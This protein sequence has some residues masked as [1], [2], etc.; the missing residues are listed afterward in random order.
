[1]FALIVG[2]RPSFIMSAPIIHAFERAD[3]TLC[4]IH[5]AQHYSENMNAVFF[6]DLNIRA[7]DHTLKAA[8][9]GLTPARQI[10]A[11]MIGV[12]DWLLRE[13]PQALMVLGDTNSNLAGAL[14]ARKLNIPLAHIEAGERSGDLTAPEE[15]NRRMIDHIADIHFATNNRSCRNLIQE[16]IA[17]ERIKVV[18]ATV[19]DSVH[20]NLQKATALDLSAKEYAPDLKTPYAVMTLHRQ[21]NVEDRD[22]LDGI[23][24]EATEGAHRLNR[25]VLFFAHPRTLKRLCEFGLTD[26]IQADSLIRLLPGAGYLEFLRVLKGATF[27]ITDSGGVQQEAC[28]L[29]VP[30]VTVM[31]STPWPDTIEIGANQL[32]KP[33]QSSL[34][35]G[36]VQAN[37]K[38][39]ADTPWRQPFGDGSAG[40][41]IMRAM[42][43]RYAT[44]AA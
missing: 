30:A 22:R 16:N 18:G 21:E 28:I 31:D 3:A 11:I 41:R 25:P 39:Y 19:V 12:E 37:Q 20:Q 23:L 13:R 17:S 4:I 35:D 38:S 34:S 24:A 26:R 42:L 36:M 7:P 29:G 1:M 2:T 9:I 32:C 27:A 8:E 6:R 5:T 40:D 43:L 44:E 14:A 15:Q 33:G 10:A